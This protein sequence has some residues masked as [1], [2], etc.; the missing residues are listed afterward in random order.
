LIGKQTDRQAERQTGRKTDRQKD[1]QAERQTGRKTD[2]QK[3]RQKDRQTD[4]SSGVQTYSYRFIFV[5]KIEVEVAV[6]PKFA[7]SLNI[8][9]FITGWCISTRPN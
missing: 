7:H 1:R 9:S 2:R 6:L 3:D 4:L 8:F 5:I